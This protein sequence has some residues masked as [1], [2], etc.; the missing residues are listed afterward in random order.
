[1]RIPNANPPDPAGLER[2]D[3]SGVEICFWGVGIR[4]FHLRLLMFIPFGD[5][6]GAQE[7][8]GRQAVPLQRGGYH[9]GA[10]A[11]SA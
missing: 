9:G 10:A 3:P 5:E 6:G 4:G 8:R 2:F 11:N 1:M 7:I